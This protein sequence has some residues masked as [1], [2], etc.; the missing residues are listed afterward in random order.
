MGKPQLVDQRNSVPLNEMGEDGYYFSVFDLK[1]KFFF[2]DAKIKDKVF[3]IRT[4]LLDSKN[5]PFREITMSK[6]I[7]H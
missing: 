5:R 3:V 2:S 4:L 7:N 6:S 1:D